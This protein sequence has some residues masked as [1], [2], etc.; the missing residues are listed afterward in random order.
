MVAQLNQ[1]Q[2]CFYDDQEIDESFGGTLW[3]SS[4]FR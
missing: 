2:I 4:S 1:A 3:P